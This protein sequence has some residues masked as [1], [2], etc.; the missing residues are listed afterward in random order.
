[1]LAA[2]QTC[3]RTI[4]GLS[5]F[6]LENEI[7]PRGNFVMPWCKSP[8]LA[9]HSWLNCPECEGRREGREGA[10]LAKVGM[11]EVGRSSTG[12]RNCHVLLTAARQTL[13][14]HKN[15]VLV[16]SGPRGLIEPGWLFI[17][18][19]QQRLRSACFCSR[20]T[21]A[22]IATLPPRSG[23]SFHWIVT[24]LL[25]SSSLSSSFFLN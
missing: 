13:P 4:A 2:K 15:L 10:R 25:L 5:I 16:C 24:L 20:A 8:S 7:T 14:L 9:L 1:M 3:R 6:P 12:C 22:G 21:T 18:A 11:L 19:L 23:H 17:R